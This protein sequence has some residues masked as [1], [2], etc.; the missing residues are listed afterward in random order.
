MKTVTFCIQKGGT[1][2]T[3]SALALGHGLHKKGYRVLF[4][5]LDAQANL[6]FSC[7]VDLLNLQ[8][9]LFDVFKGRASITDALINLDKGLDILVG[10]ID[11]A[12][13]D[14]EFTST[15]RTYMLREYLSDLENNY[16]YCIIDVPPHLG[17][18]TEN[19]L[20][21]SDTL[22]IPMRADIY[23]M[24]GIRQLKGFIDEQRKYTNPDLKI[25][26]ILLTCIKERANLTKA[27]MQPFEQIAEQLGTK[28]YKTSIRETVS[29]PETA[30]NKSNIYDYAPQATATLDYK[31]F[32]GEFLK[33]NAIKKSKTK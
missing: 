2:K 27:L 21:T 7:G 1:G 15:R 16:D 32:V 17:V 20:T 18:M 14:R 12:S 25:D 13:A 30:L 5:D 33:D 6:S 8:A 4:V 9:S 26:G 29:V 28:V 10:S 22:I 23:A 24:Q 11:L 19:A 3:T 31:A